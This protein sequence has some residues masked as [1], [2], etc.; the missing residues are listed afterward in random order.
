MLVDGSGQQCRDA[1]DERLE[2]AEDALGA[3]LARARHDEAD[4]HAGARHGE[5]VAHRV[6]HGD[7]E[8]RHPGRHESVE[9]HER[10]PEQQANGAD[11]ER[12]DALGQA[13][14]DRSEQHQ[15]QGEQGDAEV[16]DELA[17]LEVVERDG[18]QRVERADH[19]PHG[20]PERHR[21]GEGPQAQEVEGEPLGRRLD[22]LV[23]AGPEGDDR[24]G[25]RSRRGDEQERPRDP[26]RAHEHSGD[27]RPCGEP[28]DVEGQ[29]PPQVVPDALGLGDDDDPSDG[30][31]GHAHPD[32]HHEPADEQRHEVPGRR[33]H[34]QPDDVEH[35]APEHEVAGVAT[36]GDRSQEDLGQEPGEEAD[37]DDPTE[38]GLADAVLVA[39]VVEH[40]EQ[41][42][43]AHGQ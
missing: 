23:D 6:H 20:A 37:R 24:Q 35:D 15:R 3:R 8:H 9:Q 42:A 25:H 27:G 16:G 22:R 30:R 26:E 36:V 21:A 29:Q 39:D 43:V 32:A 2:P 14:A 31:H 33:H 1:G 13:P 28:T 19:H 18:P 10:G 17:R 7:G 4:G 41:G 38:R 34:Q 11:A 40:A 12:S 5:P